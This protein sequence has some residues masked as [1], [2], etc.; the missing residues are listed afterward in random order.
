MHRFF[1]YSHLKSAVTL[2]PKLGGH[3]KLLKMTP[4]DISYT[5]LYSRSVNFCDNL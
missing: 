2:K 4:F 1:K 5:T 3:L